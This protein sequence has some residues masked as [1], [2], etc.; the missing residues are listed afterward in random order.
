MSAFP[1]SQLSRSERHAREPRETKPVWRWKKNPSPRKHF[2]TQAL[3]VALDSYSLGDSSE[4]ERL[5]QLGHLEKHLAA[6]RLEQEAVRAREDLESQRCATS[7]A[8]GAGLYDEC[9]A[10]ARGVCRAR[11]ASIDLLAELDL[12][13]ALSDLAAPGGPRKP[14]PSAASAQRRDT[15]FRE[16][17]LSTVFEL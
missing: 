5:L 1:D 8:A 17:S 13:G 7:S 9:C 4:L 14:P 12:E 10:A 2:H 11:A 15:R 6:A 3:R 16:V